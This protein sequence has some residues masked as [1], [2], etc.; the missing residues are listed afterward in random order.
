MRF[1]GNIKTWNDER[2]F[3][4]IAPTQGGQ[5]IFVHIKAFRARGVRPQVGQGVTFEVELNV[6]GKKRAHAVETLRPT[7]A[8]PMRRSGGS[9]QWGAA[10]YFAIPV[11]LVVYLLVAMLW[12]VP[13]WVAS[14]YVG[15]S[16]LAFL[17][18]ALDKS[19]AVVG[20]R[21]VP[22]LTLLVVGLVGGWPG[23]IVAQQMLRHKSSKVSFRDAFW[24]TVAVNI[25]AFVLFLSPL[26]QRMVALGAS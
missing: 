23:A 6:E 12:R 17:I 1:D 14:L 19:A 7:R 18:Y 24:G 25:V 10:S 5:E 22:E 21:R 11:F 16:L 8:A 9:A 13:G 15:A 20:R 4:F 3:G 26:G 2:G